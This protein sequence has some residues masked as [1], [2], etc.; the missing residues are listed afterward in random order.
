M[1]ICLSCS[2]RIEGTRISKDSDVA[3]VITDS[4][5]GKGIP[6]IAV[7]D[8]YSFTVTDRHG[9]YQMDVDD[10][11][12]SIYYTTPAGYEIALD[13]GDHTPAF[14]ATHTPGSVFE[15]HD[16]TLTPL[17]RD[18]TDFTVFMLADP[19]CQLLKDLERFRSE[20]MPDLQARINLGISTGEME[21][22]YAMTLGD[23]VYDDQNDW[24]PM[25]EIMSNVKVDD[26]DGYLPVFQVIGNHDHYNGFYNDYDCSSVFVRNFGPTDYSFDRGKVHFVM[27][28]N[29]YYLSHGTVPDK[30]FTRVGYTSGFT[31]EQVEW[32]RQD[33]ALVEDK[34]DK[35]VIL[36]VHIPLRDIDGKEEGQEGYNYPAILAQ[37]TSFK[38]AHIMAGHTHY[39]EMFYH[40]SYKTAGGNPVMEHIH[41]AVCGAWWHCNTCVDG[42]PYGYAFYQVKGNQ[43]SDWQ[44][45][46]TGQPDTLQLRVYNGNDSYTGTKGLVYKWE[47]KF[48]DCFIATVWYDDDRYW[49]VE[50][51]MDGKVYPMTRVTEPQRD[52]Y[53]YSFF[54]NENG[55]NINNGSYKFNSLHFW[56]ASVP[57][58]DPA[59]AKDWTVRATQTVPTSG[60]VH[61]YT[62]D[63]FESGYEGL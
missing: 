10:R 42:T 34:E 15:R 9:V 51:E 6:G 59:K 13:D 14:F 4:K 38:E 33:L 25:K 48:K 49:K 46:F 12:R 39:P 22:V 45:K 50:L 30:G 55:R 36:C 27:M 28:D 16:F 61:T 37:L 23:I 17:D 2:Q 40:D 54:I 3:G 63:H 19:Q 32:L 20:T 62:S 18:E 21:N 52:W 53:A 56:T 57:G 35:M 26:Q 8:G 58:L 11:C 24:V 60:I 47:D 5:S 7:T 29:V 41:G 43:L 44:A 1:V 31:P